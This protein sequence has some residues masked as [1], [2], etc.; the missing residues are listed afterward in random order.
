MKPLVKYIEHK[1][2][3]HTDRATAWIAR[4]GPSSSGRTLYF[5]DMALKR[6]SGYDSNHY[7]L[8]SGEEVVSGL[9]QVDYRFT[10][11]PIA[12][13]SVHDINLSRDIVPLAT[14]NI[15]SSCSS[16][17]PTIS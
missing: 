17:D 3:E 12:N 7:D 13:V 6:S 16:T 14:D 1:P 8:V 15:T 5:N 11:G 10:G 2:A 9:I 4:V